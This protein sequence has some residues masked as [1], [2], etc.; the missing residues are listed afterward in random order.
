[1]HVNLFTAK[2]WMDMK[3]T[4]FWTVVPIFKGGNISNTEIARR[5]HQMINVNSSILCFSWKANAV[6]TDEDYSNRVTLVSTA[7]L[8][9]QTEIKKQPEMTFEEMCPSRFVTRSVKCHVSNCLETVDYYF[10]DVGWQSV[11]AERRRNRP[12]DRL[13]SKSFLSKKNPKYS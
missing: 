10:S 1:M 13:V 7:F 6:D 2:D 4:V 9:M 11:A 3:V 12:L 8:N 5:L